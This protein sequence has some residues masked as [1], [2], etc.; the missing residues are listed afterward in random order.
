[1]ITERWGERLW[2]GEAPERSL[3]CTKEIR[4][5][6][7]QAVG[8]ALKRAE[9]W[10]SDRPRLGALNGIAALFGGGK[11]A[12]SRSRWEF[13]SLAPPEFFALPSLLR[14]QHNLAGREPVL[15]GPVC[16][17]DLF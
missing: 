2:W 10:R 15:Q 16:F 7:N 14:N 6:P 13:G 4:E 1:V 8:Q 17:C 12:A 3:D 9:P 5:N 11:R